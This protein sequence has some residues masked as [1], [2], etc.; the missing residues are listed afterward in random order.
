MTIEE[1][2][3]FPEGWVETTFGELNVYKGQNVDPADYPNEVF[4]LYSVPNFPK[5]VPE[6]QSGEAIG[7]TKQAV[8][9][10]DVLV[11]KINPRINRVW[12]VG[13]VSDKRQIGSSEWIV[14]R[15][16]YVSK[17]FF[18]HYFRG[19][20][21]REL[22]CT[23]LTGVG[24]SLTRA[25]PSKVATFPIP[26]P[27]L[28]EQI[29][30]ADKLDTLLS[31]VDAGR[32]RL[33]R[34]PKL[35]KRFRQSVLSAAVSGELTREWRGGGDAE[36]EE[37]KFLDVCES[38][39]YGPRFSSEEYTD[40]PDG[41]PTVRTTDMNRGIIT[42]DETT[43]RVLIPNDKIEKFQAKKGDLLVTRT[44]SIGVMALFTLDIIAVPSAYLIRFRMKKNIIP[45]YAY[46]VLASP[47]GQNQLGL[48]ITAVTQPNVNAESIKAIE[49]G[50]PPLPEQAEIVRRVE[51]LFALADRL[52]VRAQVTL[53]RYSRLTPALLAKAFRGEL[54]PQDPADEPASVLLERIRA[55]RETAGPAKKA[56]GR[57]RRPGTTTPKAEV[58]VGEGEPQSG[59]KRGRG[60]PRKVQ[61]GAGQAQEAAVPPVPTA[62]SYEEAVRLLRE[63]GQAR[64][65]GARQAEL[66][67]EEVGS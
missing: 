52:E 62:G 47:F 34:V 45:P 56:P 38:S 53:A 65:E 33:K 51:A 50:L 5:G 32:E 59:Q 19:L 63:R 40:R 18:Q 55:H 44:G 17:D 61:K 20:E 23:D 7:S 66:F 10:A 31:C 1:E 42:V 2:E 64:A 25:Q 24:G 67:G 22:L 49:F 8:K 21:F 39:F 60:R 54:V 16:P 4:E 6:Y 46:F 37:V 26:L 3:R 15:S 57:G 27:P 58:G 35:V 12:Q 13:E 48:S 30:I 29:R 43:P 36:W 28:A 9:P 14:F 11:C 41:I